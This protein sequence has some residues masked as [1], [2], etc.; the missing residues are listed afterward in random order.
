MN[1]RKQSPQLHALE[2]IG[3]VFWVV[4]RKRNKPEEKKLAKEWDAE[5]A[6]EDGEDEHIIQFR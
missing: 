2:N 5:D 1:Q 3:N 4:K 6:K